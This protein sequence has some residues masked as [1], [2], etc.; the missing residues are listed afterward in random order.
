[1]ATILVVEDEPDVLRSIVSLL[2]RSEHKCV[3]AGDGREVLK[4]LGLEGGRSRRRPTSLSW[5]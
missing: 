5:T 1:M 4:I 2:E 3:S